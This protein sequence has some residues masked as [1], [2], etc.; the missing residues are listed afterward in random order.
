LSRQ[1]EKALNAKVEQIV[2]DGVRKLQ[3]M[4]NDTNE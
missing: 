3:A 2:V 4:N 1:E